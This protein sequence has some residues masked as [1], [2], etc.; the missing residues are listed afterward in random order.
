MFDSSTR[1]RLAAFVSDARRL[2]CGDYNKPGGEI[3]S[4][5]QTYG[6]QPDGTVTNLDSLPGLDQRGYELASTLR[7]VL[8]HKRANTV[9]LKAWGKYDPHVY[10]LIQEQA[11]TVLNRLC[12]LRMAEE[13]G[14]LPSP[15]I[16]QGPN[17]DGFE[18]YEIVADKKHLSRD[19]RYEAFLFSV[20]DELS[21]DLGVL[22]DRFSPHGML[23]PRSDALG[24]LLEEINHSDLAPLWEADETIGWIYQYWNSKEERKAMRDASAAPRNS[25]ELAVRNQFFTPRYVVEFLTDNTLGRIWYEMTKGETRLAEQCRYLVRRPNEIFLGPGEQAPHLSRPDPELKAII[26]NP[27]EAHAKI[28]PQADPEDYYAPCGW[29]AEAFGG[30]LTNLPAEDEMYARWVGAAVPP[31]Q[32]ESIIGERWQPFEDGTKLDRLTESILEGNPDPET[33]DLKV[34]WAILSAFA[35]TSQ[36]AGGYERPDWKKLWSHFHNRAQEGC[37]VQL[38]PEE[39]LSQE[40]LLK[41]PVHIPHRPVKDPREIRLLDPACGS[42]HFGLYAFDLFEVIYE[43]SWDN[44]LCPALQEAYGKKA[45]YLRDVPRLIIEHNIHGVDID[46]RAVQ[47]AGLSLWLRAQKTWKDTPAAARPRVRRSNIVCAEPMPGS[48]AMLE[49]FVQT[50]DPPLLGELV[51]TVFDKMQLAGEAGTL[52]KIEEE[53]RTAIDDAKAKWEKLGAAERNLFSAEELNQTLRP[54]AQQELTGVEKA[55]TADHRPLATDFFDTAEERIYTALRNYAESA[56]AGDYQRRLFAEDAAHGFAF[57]DLCRKR[58]DAVVMNPPFGDLAKAAKPYIDTQYSDC[59]SDYYPAFVRRCTG[60]IVSGGLIGTISNRTGFFLHRLTNW[61][62]DYFGNS[63]SLELFFDLGHGVLDALVETAAYTIRGKNLDQIS[64]LDRVLCVDLLGTVSTKREHQMGTSIAAIKDGHSG[65]TTYF[66][67]YADALSIPGSPLGYRIPRSFLAAFN[68]FPRLEAGDRFIRVT[69]PKGDDFRYHRLTW[70]V[71]NQNIG[72]TKRWSWLAKGGEY[73][74]Y[75]GDIHL[76]VDWDDGTKTFRGFLGTPHR[77]LARPASCDLFFKLGLTFSRRTA[78]RFACRVLPSGSIFTDKGPGIFSDS[79]D[80]LWATLA[81][82]NSNTFQGFLELFM[83]AGDATSSGSAARSYEAGTVRNIPVPELSTTSQVTLGNLA[84]AAGEV[85]RLETASEEHSP[86]FYPSRPIDTERSLHDTS[87]EANSLLLGR[88]LDLL[89]ITLDIEKIVAT[90]YDLDEEGVSYVQSSFGKHPLE[91]ESREIDQSIREACELEPGDLIAQ[92]VRSGNTGRFI[93]TK[94]FFADRKIEVLAHSHKL[95]PITV[96]D[97]LKSCDLPKGKTVYLASATIS[98]VVG[99]SVGRWD[100]RYATGE[101]QPPELP[102]PFDPLPI[103]PPGMLQ[104]ADGLPMEKAEGERLKAKGKYPLR[105]S[106]EGILVDDESHPE[107]IAARVRNA[108]AVIWGD[109]SSAIEHEACEILGVRTLR[110]YFAEKRSGGKF[111]K[112]HLKRYSKSRRQAPI[113]WPLSTE[114]GSYTL[115]IYYHRLTEDT[116]YACITNFVAPKQEQSEKTLARLAGKG[117]AR[118]AAEDKEYEQ[119]EALIGELATF[120]AELERLAKIWKPNLNDG[121]QITAAP[122]WNLFRLKPWQKKLKDT[123]DKLE[124]GDYDWAH[125]AHTLWPERVIPKCASDRS[126]AIA[127]GYEEDLWEEVENDKGKLVWQPRKDADGIV[128]QL[129]CSSS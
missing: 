9:G 92:A 108:L 79:E 113:Y 100:I 107:D 40:E 43:E 88:S 6:I 89:K 2:L 13:R 103:C 120:R 68:K 82:S 21:L 87:I 31:E 3:T 94:S 55:L 29:V 17:S 122:L 80:D 127:H 96:I 125:L 98:M 91:Y 34:T 24:E 11:F 126:L 35:R 10:D 47:I 48:D 85:K 36:F 53:I 70:E 49:D 66:F 38:A 30:D 111:F 26:G 75:Y 12:A 119:T 28:F 1:N 73:A 116:L 5:L 95:S 102:G 22:F 129:I 118:S 37:E 76:L 99:Y 18:L 61:R 51:K 84:R 123:W 81:I 14:I 72:K 115:W 110:D 112:D 16:S 27:Q 57:I 32:I 104:N 41:Q 59:N 71:P 90:S 83:G 46:P 45:D 69:N 42:M 54:G 77:P 52:L 7:D 117:D 105:I 106:W 109:R 15:V 114:S 56:E 65:K 124:A 86:Q 19:E 58:Y 64:T 74:P 62:Q 101:R 93:T 121:V 8:A 97:T 33:Q 60:T 44:G 67:R 50:L 128:E 20:F 23:F 4:I 78:S 63:A 25:R 39:T